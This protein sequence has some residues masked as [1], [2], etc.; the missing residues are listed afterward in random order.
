[1]TA[2]VEIFSHL[3]DIDRAAWNAC[4]AH[5]LENY[6]YL[7]TVER[8][9]LPDFTWRYV[10]VINGA[11]I[12]AACPAFITDYHLDT[13][14]DD[15]AL[16]RA[17]RTIK[18]IAPGFLRL[19]L[20]SLGSSLM[21]YGKIGFHPDV[22]EREKPAFIKQLLVGFEQHARAMGCKMFG[23][24]DIPTAQIP[25]WQL[26]ITDLGYTGLP[27][28]PAGKLDI[29]FASE[30]GYFK[31]LS[32]MARKDVRRKLR[33]RPEIRTEIR[34][35][36]TDVKE[37]IYELYLATKNRSEFQFETLTPEYFTEILK[38]MPQQAFYVLYYVG[39]ELVGANLLLQ[40]QTTLLDKFFCMSANGRAHHLYFISWVE[41]I[42][43]A[44][45]HGQ[46]AYHSGQASPDTKR[47]LGCVMLETQMLFRHTSPALNQILKWIAPMFEMGE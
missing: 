30:D 22:P 15:G 46:R 41:N 32:R 3:A 17:I 21:E 27:G 47:H 40:N 18:K 35:D 20:G 8:A 19:K 36:I 31:T 11:K 29:T 34:A 45:A 24:K 5:E 2:R 37:K 12:L 1:M 4:F 10:A 16:R 14:L 33:A 25:A 26:A 9:A 43:Y 7:L 28:M 6:D 39:A 13:T 42:R 44:L 38:H 23:I